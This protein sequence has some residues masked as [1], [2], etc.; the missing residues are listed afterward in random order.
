ML[1][2]TV[3][4]FSSI[5]FFVNTFP[6]PPAQPSSQ[7]SAELI[8]GGAAA[9]KIV[10]IHVLHLAGP[11]LAGNGVL[12]YLISSAHPTRFPA[13]FTIA[14]GLNGSTAWNLGQTWSLNLTTYLL[15]VP[16]TITISIVSTTQLLFHVPLPGTNPVLPPQFVVQGTNPSNPTVDQP[17]SV[18]VQIV[19][20]ALLSYSVFASVSQVPGSG[21]PA[22]KQMTYSASTGQFSISFPNGATLAGTYYV[23]VNA[24]DNLSQ[25]NTVA[26]PIVIGTG[27]IPPAGITLAVS[28]VPPVNQTL[29]TIYATVLNTGA[30]PGTVNVTFHVGAT[31]IGTASGPITAGGT[32]TFSHTWTPASTGTFL[33]TAQANV[34]GGGTPTGALNVTVLPRVELIS[35]NVLALAHPVNNTS[36]YLAEAISAAGYPVTVIFVACNA[37]LPTA[38]AMEAYDLVVIDFGSASTG[39]CA[40]TPSTTEQAKI[41][42]S[43]AAVQNDF[44]IVG[45][46]F[47]TATACGSYGATLL[48]DFG[49]KGTSGTCFGTSASAT[50]AATYTSNSAAGFRRDGIGALTINK[51]LNGVST[52]VPYAIFSQGATNQWFSTA[53]GTV[54]SWAKVAN[55]GRGVAL[56]TDPAR[57]MTTLPA[58][59][60]TAWGI[61]A[62]GTS[63]AYNVLNFLSGLSSASSPGRAFPDFAI[64]GATLIGISAAHLTQVYVT[65]RA[66]GPVG[67]LVTASLAVNGTIALYE[68]LPV[69]AT[70][71]LLPNGQNVTVVLTWE[72]STSGPYTIGIIAVSFDGSLFASMGQ[73]PI[74]ILNEPTVFVP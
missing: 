62:G 22:V 4:L 11:T 50:T 19:D 14:Q 34:T 60:S 21:L 47:F 52:T 66:N 56:G 6:R 31:T 32:A 28:P 69:S 41:T 46:S 35:H 73:L 1:A 26:I 10:G 63:V 36:A 38:V 30:S 3:T 67:G 43:M 7:F 48:T 61:G 9:N 5:F 42:T 8:Y 45:A 27:P 44:F 20:S 13:P 15:T 37:A 33:I 16:D 24:T 23:F 39:T 40:A 64:S 71:A 53:S 70:V 68:G 17:F 2:L 25:T 74:N 65:L 29:E 54:G 58:P 49:I 72:S 59:I 51:T 57:L 55:V 18:Y 12:F